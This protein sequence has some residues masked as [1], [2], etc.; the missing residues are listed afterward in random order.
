MAIVI[1]RRIMSGPSSCRYANRHLCPARTPG[2]TPG[3]SPRQMLIPNARLSARLS[4]RR[5]NLLQRQ[6]RAFIQPRASPED[7]MQVPTPSAESAIQT[8]ESIPRAPPFFAARNFG[9]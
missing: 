7:G 2:T 1:L 3:D 8:T 6:R 9:I 5:T 4:H